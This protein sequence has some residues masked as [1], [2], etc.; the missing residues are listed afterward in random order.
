MIQKLIVS[1]TFKMPCPLGNIC[2]RLLLRLAFIPFLWALVAEWKGL[3]IVSKA[4]GGNGVD[5]PHRNTQL[6]DE[7]SGDHGLLVDFSQEGQNILLVG[8][9]NAS[10]Y[11]SL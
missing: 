10:A 3:S 2:P 4:P 1:P 5:L 9:R 6:C 7:T 11:V 8:T